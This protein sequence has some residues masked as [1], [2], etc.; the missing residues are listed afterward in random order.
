MTSRGV[1]RRMERSFDDFFI[2]I[3]TYEGQHRHPCPVIEV[4]NYSDKKRGERINQ[5]TALDAK[6]MIVGGS[7]H[8]KSK[9]KFSRNMKRS[10]RA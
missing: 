2:V 7:F 6:L 4:L 5:R 10:N 1:K 3:T 8:S 9:S